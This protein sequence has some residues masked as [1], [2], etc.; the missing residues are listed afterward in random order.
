MSQ[1]GGLRAAMGTLADQ[2]ELENARNWATHL[3]AVPNRKEAWGD[4]LGKL[5]TL[6]GT[7][8]DVWNHFA[9]DDEATISERGLQP[10]PEGWD[11]FDWRGDELLQR[12]A[13][14]SLIVHSARF[15]K[16]AKEAAGSPQ[17]E[18]AQ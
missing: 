2:N 14:Y 4:A 11:G 7:P 17:T 10:P 16:R 3:A 18:A 1:I 6:L 8:G 13:I 15:H 12:L 9:P 5:R